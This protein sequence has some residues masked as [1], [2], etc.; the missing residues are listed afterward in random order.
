MGVVDRLE[1]IDIGH[2]HR[3]R[4]GVAAGDGQLGRQG[5]QDAAAVG[6]PG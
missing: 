2:Q 3:Q 4:Q 5:F 6:D 1:M